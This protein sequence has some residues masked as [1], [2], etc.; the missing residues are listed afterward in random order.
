MIGSRALFAI[1]VLPASL[2]LPL[3]TQL[4]LFC[5]LT[6]SIPPIATERP[7]LT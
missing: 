4:W 5:V 7:W 2:L 1:L 6:V 3:S